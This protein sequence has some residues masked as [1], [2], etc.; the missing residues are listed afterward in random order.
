MAGDTQRSCLEGTPS[1]PQSHCLP[2]P[3]T[4]QPRSDTI[5]STLEASVTLPSIRSLLEYGSPAP[6]RGNPTD[7]RYASPNAVNGYR[8]PSHPLPPREPQQYLPL[9][10][11]Q[12]QPQAQPQSNPRASTYPP[13]QPDQRRGYY[14]DRRPPYGQEAYG[15]DLYQG[16]RHIPAGVYEYSPVGHGSAPP[17]TQIRC[18]G[19][20]SAPGGK[21]HNCTRMN[22]ECIFQP[23]SSL[24][25][26]ALVHVSA[27]QGGIPLGTQ[28]FGAYGQPL[29]LDPIL[30][31]LP[32]H[33]AYQHSNAP[34]PP[35]NY[36]VPVQAPAESFSS[37]VDARTD[38]GS[39]LAGRRR[40]RTSEEQDDAY[41][42]P[43]PLSAVDQDP[44]RMSP[45][46]YSICSIPGGVGVS[47]VPERKTEPTKPNDWE[48][49]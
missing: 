10:Q 20:Q 23:V 8:P 26:T 11:L 6:G 46:E 43:P 18:R 32:P 7:P 49:A 4:L 2:P 3:D 35:A 47:S 1:G 24:N 30:A 31:S 21:C 37:Y 40:R 13:P 19:Y 5:T 42:L 33:A 34:P 17:S 22:Q 29:A 28:L 15:T 36:C 45:A 14:D 48:I 44:R 16:Y 27:L 25:S 12:F 41:R 9:L 38:D 39:Q